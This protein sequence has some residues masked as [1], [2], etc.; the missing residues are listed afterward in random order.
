M[1]ALYGSTATLS[2]QGNPV[3]ISGARVT[4][5]FFQTLGIE[6]A[7]GRGFTAD[8]HH[9]GVSQAVILSHELWRS[10]FGSDTGII[11]RKLI[12]NGSPHEVVGVLPRGT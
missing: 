12:L 7:I 1:T 8:E 10:R 2:G 11:G 3:R 4:D 6:P 5:D 9:A